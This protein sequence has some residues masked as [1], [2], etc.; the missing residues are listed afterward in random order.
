MA[1]M[2]KVEELMKA[3]KTR[4]CQ[5]HR[6]QEHM[7]TYKLDYM[8]SCRLLWMLFQEELG[9]GPHDRRHQGRDYSGD[10]NLEEQFLLDAGRCRA[11]DRTHRLFSSNQ[12][13]AEE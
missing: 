13:D 7:R 9:G 3:D 5:P 6:G 8:L 2:I 12:T 10:G 4:Y 1:T 11:E